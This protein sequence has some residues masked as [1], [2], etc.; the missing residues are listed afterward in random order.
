V[1]LDC[2]IKRTVSAAGIGEYPLLTRG[3]IARLSTVLLSHLHEDHCAALPLLLAQGYKGQVLASGWTAARTP[4]V[5]DQ[6]SQYV[7]SVSG[8]L[9]FSFSHLEGL[10]LTSLPGSETEGQYREGD[11]QIN[12]GRTGHI[13]GSLWF[14]LVWEGERYFYSGDWCPGG[15][16]LEADLP[17][18]GE[19]AVAMIDA[20]YGMDNT[21]RSNY[22]EALW[23][24]CLGVVSQGGRALLPMPSIGRCQEWLALLASKESVLAELGVSVVVDQSVLGGLIEYRA[25]EDWLHASGRATLK[26]FPTKMIKVRAPK[27]PWPSVGQPGIWIASEGMVGTSS[28]Q[29]AIA[30]IA[31]DPAS[32]VFLTGHQAPGTPGADILAGRRRDLRCQIRFAR[33]KV[34]PSLRDNLTLLERVQPRRVVLVHASSD[35]AAPLADHLRSLGY[36]VVLPSPG[37]VIRLS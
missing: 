9:P 21:S 14:D 12:W 30:A 35:Q 36:D 16:L 33:L 27:D 22:E 31:D 10:H 37:D 6:W 5:V 15:S 17:P 34:H 4:R 29:V 7:T 13:P 32:G 1:L 18:K 25:S 28:S 2:G 8:Q 24:A 11:L 23:E 19:R 26:N 3:L 20:T